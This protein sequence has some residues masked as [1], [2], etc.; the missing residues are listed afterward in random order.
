MHSP[1]D[2]LLQEV[3]AT[4]KLAKTPLDSSLQVHLQQGQAFK[5]CTWVDLLVANGSRR[6]GSHAEDV[7]LML[8]S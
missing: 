6:E 4:A 5:V 8:P 7:L 1:T 3:E 2:S